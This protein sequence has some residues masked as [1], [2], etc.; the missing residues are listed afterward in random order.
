MG[1]L[2]IDI[3][4]ASPFS[5]PQKQEHYRDTDY[6]ELVAVALGYQPSAGNEIETTVL[7]REGGWEPGQTAELLDRVINWCDQRE[8][9][10]TLTYNGKGFDAIHLKNWAT[11]LDDRGI[12][13]NT[14][15][16]VDDLFSNHADLAIPAVEQHN[17]RLDYRDFPKFEDV[18]RWEGI[19]TTPTYY[20]DYDLDDELIAIQDNQVE[21]RHIG[22]ELGEQYVHWSTAGLQ[23][24]KSFSELQRLLEDY[25]TTDVYPLYEL[26]EAL[27]SVNE[28]R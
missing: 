8:I 22:T 1:T 10:Q 2:A 11:N 19:E 7:F 17:D 21:G 3:E 15:I 13:S 27:R 14:R 16:Q 18:C 9:S 12:R 6:F 24:T 20:A 4:T 5:E 26:H 25:A 28:E 23:G